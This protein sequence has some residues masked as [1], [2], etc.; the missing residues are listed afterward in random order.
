L[1]RQGS[2]VANPGSVFEPS[3]S[4]TDRARFIAKKAKKEGRP[5]AAFDLFHGK[6]RGL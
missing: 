1:N 3:T 4:S 6:S 5:E 2:K